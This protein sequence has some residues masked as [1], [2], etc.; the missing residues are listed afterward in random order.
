MDHLSCAFYDSLV[1]LTEED[2]V[3]LLRGETISD[4]S[5]KIKLNRF[6]ET[7]CSTCNENIAKRE[8]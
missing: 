2:I 7:D 1:M 4:G 5:L 8:K 3:L 6:P